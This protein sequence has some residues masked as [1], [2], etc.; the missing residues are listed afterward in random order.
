MGSEEEY[1]TDEGKRKKG[2]EDSMEGHHRTKRVHKTPSRGR[3]PEE[4][5]DKILDMLSNL[6]QEI[7]EL[8][9]EQK[10]YREEMITMKR[11]NEDLKKENKKIKE[12]LEEVEKKVENMERIERR[13]NVVIQGIPLTT[14]DENEMKEK[15]DDLLE[16]T[17]GLNIKAQTVRKVNERVCVVK[18][19][20]ST[21]KK[22]IMENK[23][24]LREVKNDEIYIN[25]D[26]SKK[27]REIQ[28]KIRK[29]AKDE[30]LRGNS[31]KIGFQK[32]VVNGETRVWDKTE[33][34][35]IAIEMAKN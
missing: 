32:L 29:E 9:Y 8:R 19:K 3:E 1:T 12:R 5:V 15:V 21:D 33:N 13:N 10:E 4:K 23:N 22:Q 25:D 35:F 17:L 28:K 14:Y 2:L 24:K 6:T 30:R 7:K 34:R 18:L 31:V 11:E 26:M 20:N 27:E 16:K